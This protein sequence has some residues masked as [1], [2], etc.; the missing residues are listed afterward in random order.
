MKNNK[1]RVHLLWFILLIAIGFLLRIRSMIAFQQPFSVVE[2]LVFLAVWSV[3]MLIVGEIVWWLTKLIL[4]LV[5]HQSEV[6]IKIVL[7][8]AA[9]SLVIGLVIPLNRGNPNTQLPASVS[10]EYQTGVI[11]EINTERAKLGYPSLAVDEKLCALAKKLAIDYEKANAAEF[12]SPK[13]LK[14]PVYSTYLVGYKSALS[15]AVRGSNVG[16]E[17][18]KELAQTF[19]RGEGKSASTLNLTHGCV[20]SSDG[21]NSDQVYAFFVGAVK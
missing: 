2:I 17:T 15:D 1:P 4:K 19:M 3:A 14:D 10:G 6:D 8:L 7:G 5:F 9:I 21:D 12:K 11:D 20:A 13:L 18:R 16:F